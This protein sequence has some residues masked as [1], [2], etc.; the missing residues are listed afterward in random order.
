[1]ANSIN[2]INLSTRTPSPSRIFATYTKFDEKLSKIIQDQIRYE[3]NVMLVFKFIRIL[4]LY[5]V[6]LRKN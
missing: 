6:C 2:C 4:I 5:Y 1:M 3:N